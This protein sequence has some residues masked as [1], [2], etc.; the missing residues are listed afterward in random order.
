MT[1][2]VERAEAAVPL[3]PLLVTGLGELCR[4]AWMT[5]FANFVKERTSVGGVRVFDK[6]FRISFPKSEFMSM[7]FGTSLDD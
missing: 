7:G 1:K 6:D 4:W 5:S 2:G 3:E